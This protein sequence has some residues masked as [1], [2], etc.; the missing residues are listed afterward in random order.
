MALAAL[1][2]LIMVSAAAL[3]PQVQA[4]EDAAFGA[5]ALVLVGE[6]R[7]GDRVAMR[8][9]GFTVQVT[10]EEGVW[11]EK[12]GGDSAIRIGTVAGKPGCRVRFSGAQANDVY[13]QLLIRVQ[14]RGYRYARGRR[15][16]AEPQV[17]VDTLTGNVGP[18][19][20]VSMFRM[21]DPTATMFAMTLFPNQRD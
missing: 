10:D 21:T 2:A 7:V 5:C 1:H 19:A 16:P 20:V 3:S 4:A 9:L 8:K 12:I 17:V 6:A 15:A 14:A 13:E 18:I 11:A